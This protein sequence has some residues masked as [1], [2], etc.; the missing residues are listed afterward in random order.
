MPSTSRVSIVTPFYNTRL[1]LAECI[2]SVLRQSHQNWEYVLVDNHSDDGSTEI[3]QEY[4]AR[5]PARIR[6]LRPPTFLSQVANYNFALSCISPDSR[7]CKIV[8]ADDWIYPECIDR[9][10]T[11][12]DSDETIGIVSSYRIK[13][14][15]VLGGG[16]S[17][18][19]SILP[20]PELCRLQLTAPVFVFGT[21]TTVLYRSVLVREPSPLYDENTFFDD[22]DACYRILG[23]WKFGFVHQVLSFSRVDA[24][25]I[26]GRVIDFNPD[27][28]DTYLQ[29][30]KFGPL[31]LSDA[32]LAPLV[33]CARAS[34]YSF[35]AR[36]F[37][38]GADAAF[39]EF[40]TSG[41]SSVGL[42]IDK[43]LLAR[44]TLTEIARLAANP[45][46][47]ITRMYR[48]IRSRLPGESPTRRST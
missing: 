8:Q 40:H 21:P 32:E 5:F 24:D 36:R 27:L 14:N 43:L 10:V 42:R 12:A 20:G 22:A 16:L 1:Y 17:P 15:Q 18:S 39:W 29:V 3:A 44:H 11:L 48:E 30:S 46:F 23:S 6:L 2:E 38:A 35:L 34:Y 13:G 28:L 7:Y 45:G 19:L 37:L 25:S 33:A 9:L 4:A 26:R 41:L 31:Y 47:T